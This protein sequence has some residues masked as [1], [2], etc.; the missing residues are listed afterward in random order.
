MRCRVCKSHETFL[1]LDLGNHPPSNQFIVPCGVVPNEEP[2][3]LKV[4]TCTQCWLM[5]TVDTVRR[6]KLFNENYP[7]LALIPLALGNT[8]HLMQRQLLKNCR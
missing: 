6:E 7:I 5:Q 2:F 1:V 8:L 4:F 3:P